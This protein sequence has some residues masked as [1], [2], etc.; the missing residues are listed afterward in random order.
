MTIATPPR[1]LAV[2]LPPALRTAQAAAHSPDVQEILP[3]LSAY[4]LGIFM[5]HR[6][7]EVIGEFQPLPDK[8]V[9]AE[10]GLEVSFQQSA[11]P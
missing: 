6:H 1:N 8:V 7:D 11:T 3:C 9:Q 2:N 5:P 10:S 4:G